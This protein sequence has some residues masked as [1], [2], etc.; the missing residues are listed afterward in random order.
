MELRSLRYF[1]AVAELGSVSAAAQLMHM[2]QPA[3]SRQLRQLEHE[4]KLALFDRHKGRLHLT[5]AGRQFLPVAQGVL[6]N[7]D[8]ATDTAQALA[9]GR[10]TH[11]T[12]AAPTTT[13]ADVIAP[14]LAGFTPH[15]PLPTVVET[16]GVA[17]QEHHADLAILTQPPSTGWHHRVL[18]VLPVWAYVPSGHRWSQR[19]SIPLNEL[20]TE[21]LIVLDSIR[22][23][24]Q[25]LQEA[26]NSARLAAPEIIECGHARV[27]QALAAAGRGVAVVSDDPRFE[28]HGLHI[29]GPHGPLR[30]TLYAVW[31]PTHHAASTLAA[32]AER[33]LV[34]C[35]QRYGLQVVPE[36]GQ[37]PLHM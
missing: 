5:A 11:L 3:L 27:A 34:F 15:D 19:A 30:I 9:A 35:S 16:T 7:A 28:L 4:L 36:P 18:A 2:T 21:T 37:H 14:F 20:V 13:F 12:I 32:L 26:L 8:N 1:V 23:A 33:L 29:D 17:P 24:R 25:I 6:R 10:L 31:S 22:R